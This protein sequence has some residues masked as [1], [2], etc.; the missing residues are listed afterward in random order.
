MLESEFTEKEI[1]IINSHLLSDFGT[2]K[3]CACDY[4]WD[5]VLFF[6]RV[7][8]ESTNQLELNEVAL[9]AE[10]KAYNEEHQT[11]VSKDFLMNHFWIRFVVG[12]YKIPMGILRIK[13]DEDWRKELNGAIDEEYLDNFQFV[14]SIAK[15]Y[16]YEDTRKNVISIERLES[17]YK[18]FK[19]LFYEMP[20]LENILEQY[21]IEKKGDKFLLEY[22]IIEP[23][24]KRFLSQLLYAMLNHQDFS[25]DE[26]NICTWLYL[27]RN[28]FCPDFYVSLPEEIAERYLKAAYSILENE[29]DLKDNHEPEKFYLDEHLSFCRF[30][31]AKSLLMQDGL[32][33]YIIDTDNLFVKWYKFFDSRKY[34]GASY[35]DS[36]VR[37]DYLKL[38]QSLLIGAVNSLHNFDI[39]KLF[40]NRSYLLFQTL[41]YFERK[42]P[43]QLLKFLDHPKYG[44]IFLCSFLLI[45]EEQFNRSPKGVSV[46]EPFVAKAVQIFYEK[47]LWNKDGYF[48]MSLFL[49]FILHRMYNCKYFD[50][51]KKIFNIAKNYE[52]FGR[53]S[54]EQCEVLLDVYDKYSEQILTTRISEIKVCNFQYLFF[55]Y[56]YSPETFKKSIL[57]KIHTLYKESIILNTSFGY[58]EEWNHLDEIEWEILYNDLYEREV[59]ESFSLSILENLNLNSEETDYQ[60]R[61]SGPK[62]L[63]THLKIMSIVYQ[64]WCKYEDEVKIRKLETLLITILQHCL[65]DKL[66]QGCVN[67]FKLQ[68]ESSI[69]LDFKTELFSEII[70]V[71]NNF[72]TEN[73]NKFFTYLIRGDELRLLVKTFNLLVN[74]K[75]KEKLRESICDLKGVDSNV[76]SFP[77]YIE[78]IRDLYNSHIDDD[79]TD[80]LLDK[81]DG[82]LN[83][84]KN[85]NKDFTYAKP[86]EIL[87]LYK[88]FFKKDK[89][90][91]VKYKEHQKTSFYNEIENKR[92]YLL[93]LLL[94]EGS[95]YDSAKTLLINLK[96]RKIADLKND[97]LLMYIKSLQNELNDKFIELLKNVDDTL[98]KLMIDVRDREIQNEDQ[99]NFDYLILAKENLLLKLKKYDALMAYFSSLSAEHQKELNYVK[100]AIEAL[101]CQNKHEE[102]ANLFCNIIP[103][104]SD[105]SE[106]NELKDKISWNEK[107][108]TLSKAYL[109]ILGLRAVD[110]FKVL[111][112][113]INDHQNDLG[114][115]LVYDLCFSLNYLL[116]KIKAAQS[117]SGFMDS[118]KTTLKKIAGINENYKT[119]LLRAVV[120]SRLTMLNYKFDEQNRSGRSEKGIDAGELDMSIDLGCST[121]VIEALN[122]S[123][124]SSD[125]IHHIEKTFKY[126]PSNTL[127]INLMYYEGKNEK[128]VDTWNLIKQ[129][130]A[131]SN[132]ISYPQG[133]AYQSQKELSVL[134]N[135]NG[136]KVLKCIHDGN[137]VFYHILANFSYIN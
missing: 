23:Y 45:V 33:D 88:L 47:N 31:D 28:S 59:L 103:T 98:E 7:L 101:V 18:S 27:T 14:C 84:K 58:W 70:S 43:A 73:K 4:S 50:F 85:A 134:Y 124:W 129:K 75:D 108:Q 130:V 19:D 102:A 87:K 106:Y 121:A 113:E 29:G 52:K 56:Q 62:K 123:G 35:F 13:E 78:L 107:I 53:L 119:D 135:N 97:I 89:D 83:K 63:R 51:Y 46:V 1:Q 55:L 30:R 128:F 86:I 37:A 132:T 41:F 9:N 11:S 96:K 112:P 105:E 66:D 10:I 8:L 3:E 114:L 137:L 69:G 39:T 72:L 61:I 76:F 49:M 95:N 5:S 2:H 120:N 67:I 42:N 26:K 25:D 36:D 81:L 65:G 90:G 136:L 24:S 110:R 104:V 40:D 111:P 34:V 38:L 118:L 60:K 77:D 100:P 82:F 16:G 57:D 32:E 44:L 116:K 12:R 122:C 74:S 126:D 91:L 79:F 54:A 109:D 93:V 80:D 64:K 17:I 99:E 21:K 133:Y 131:D 68:Y 115:F 117:Y 127:L 71:V 92:V 48:Q 6:S 15:K 22:R 20:S 94:L 125:I